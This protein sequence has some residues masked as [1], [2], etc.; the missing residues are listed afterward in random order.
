MLRESG[1]SST[2]QR[3]PL[4]RE[5]GLLDHPLTRTMTSEHR[6]AQSREVRN[7]WPLAAGFAS[8][9]GARQL[10]SASLHHEGLGERVP[11]PTHVG[12][13]GIA[14]LVAHV[15]ADQV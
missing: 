9:G 8:D 7:L 6:V 1:A 2:D 5:W 15:I 4:R 10:G 12:S 11:R 3:S 14:V 13:G